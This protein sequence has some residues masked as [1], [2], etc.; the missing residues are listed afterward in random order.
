MKYNIKDDLLDINLAEVNKEQYL[1]SKY[2]QGILKGLTN[3]AENGKTYYSI[4]IDKL[5]YMSS[6]S[7]LVALLHSCGYRVEC[8][9]ED[10]L[11]FGS[12]YYYDIFF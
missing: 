6:K 4:K 3:A 5:E 1:S 7:H 2:V 12:N 11:L 8:R 10:G 9:R